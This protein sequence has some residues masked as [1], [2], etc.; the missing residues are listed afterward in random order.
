MD[1]DVGHVKLLFSLVLCEQCQNRQ[2]FNL[3]TG[4]KLPLEQI[5]GHGTCTEV[6]CIQ[7]QQRCKLGTHM[8]IEGNRYVIHV[9]NT[10]IFE[11]M[12]TY[13]SFNMCDVNILH[14]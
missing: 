8:P 12:K 10:N 9:K 6:N 1:I 14:R 2:R 11:L 5:T 7:I 13:S 3:E 4:G